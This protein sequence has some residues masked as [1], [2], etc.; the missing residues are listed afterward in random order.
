MKL[1][2]GGGSALEVP[3]LRELERTAAALRRPYTDLVS[4]L[5]DAHAGDPGWWVTPVASR[6]VFASALFLRCCRLHLA[7]RL[8]ADPAVREIVVESPGVAAALRNA[9]AATRPEIRVRVHGGVLRYRACQILGTAW[10]LAAALYN[11][12][13]PYLCWRLSGRAVPVP[14]TIPIAIL[15]TFLYRDSFDGVFR[16]RH[17]PGLVEHLLDSE[18]RDIYFLASYYRVRNHFRLFRALRAS[19][20]QFLVKEQFL[21]AADYLHVLAHAFRLSSY[22]QHPC[23]LEGVNI[24]PLLD[25]A[26]REAVAG[27]GSMEGLLR[28]RLARRLHESGI[29][30]RSVLEWFENQEIDHGS[31]AGFRR[32]HPGARITGYQ[33]FVVSPL[34]LGIFPT[35]TEQRQGF[36]P[37]RVAVTG[38]GLIERAKE[39]CPQ[40]EV[41]AAPAFRYAALH[42][43]APPQRHGAVPTVLIALPL[44]EREARDLMQTVAAVADELGATAGNRLRMLLRAHPS[45]APR[46]LAALAS[47]ARQSALE[48]ST[49][50]FD[51]LLDQA[52][53]LVSI[54]STACVQAVARG[55]PVVV[56]GDSRGLT[57]NPIPDG[58]PVLLWSLCHGASEVA[59]AIRNFVGRDAAA[60]ARGRELGREVLTQ[61]F[62]PVTRAGV[63]HL[64]DLP[65]TPANATGAD[66]CA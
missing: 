15:D 17:Y 46:R 21:S 16:D 66:A 26:L 25:E 10:R 53:V 28:F 40:L 29:R 58:T 54:A 35:T 57:F 34:H 44:M 49:G 62:A 38:P 5:G 33:G 6:N 22:R 31:V 13:S 23:T 47:L 12:A 39:F 50:G 18:R 7:V 43:E 19:G 42:R 61:C 37:H 55:I 60:V 11:C 32:Y 2:L 56:V 9:L 63:L 64:L 27:S 1:D 48:W 52:D 20:T 30:V 51:E 41:F 36:L 59:G 4:R 14:S 24:A 45:T 8:A 3:Q 65:E